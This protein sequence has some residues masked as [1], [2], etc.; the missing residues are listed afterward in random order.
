MIRNGNDQNARLAPVSVISCLNISSFFGSWLLVLGI[1]LCLLAPACQSRPNKAPPPPTEGLAAPTRV[2]AL[3]TLVAPP[4]GWK[5]DPMKRSEQHTHQAWLSPT[6]HTAYG[7][8][9]FSMP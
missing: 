9:H 6:G 2:P 5:P 1:C 4:L 7:V 3:A 8:I